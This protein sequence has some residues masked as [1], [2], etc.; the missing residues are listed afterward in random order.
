MRMESK[1]VD[2][3]EKQQMEAH[4]KDGKGKYEGLKTRIY[5]DSEKSES[6]VKE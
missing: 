3:P 2:R 1:I 5:E 4:N 6:E